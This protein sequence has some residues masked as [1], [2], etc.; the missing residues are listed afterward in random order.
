[1]KLAEMIEYA[2]DQYGLTEETRWTAAEPGVTVLCDSVTDEWVAVLIRKWDR[3][4]DETIEMFDIRCDPSSPLI[5]HAAYIS[6]PF[7]MRR[8]GW[9]GVR[10]DWRA[11][12]EVVFALLDQAVRSQKERGAAIV[13]D[14]PAEIMKSPGSRTFLDT[15]LPHPGNPFVQQ[16]DM[17]PDRIREMLRLYDH[18]DM[19]FAGKC[20]NFYRQAVFMKDYED[21]V[22][23]G[24]G[25]IRRYFPTYHD[26]SIRE[27]RGYFA[28][29][30]SVRQGSCLPA[31]YVYAEIYF[32]ELLNQIGTDS[33]EESLEKMQAFLDMYAEQNRGDFNLGPMKTWMLDFSVI[34]ALPVER[35]QPLL[36]GEEWRKDRM[37]GVLQ[38]PEK[39]DD[40]TVLNA[41]LAFGDAR[42]GR[43]PVLQ[44]HHEIGARLFAWSWRLALRE[45]PDLFDSFFGRLQ[46]MPWHPLDSAVY[47]ER[48]KLEP[49]VCVLTPC[50]TFLYRDGGWMQQVRMPTKTQW[51]KFAGFLREADRQFRLYLKTGNYLKAQT[52]DAWAAPFIQQAIGKVRKE[53]EEAERPKLVL[54]LSRLNGIRRDAEVTRD[55]LLISEEAEEKDQAQNEGKK[56]PAAKDSPEAGSPVSEAAFVPVLSDTGEQ[57]H[58]A[59]SVSLT[60]VQKEILRRLLAGESVRTVLSAQHLM[61]SVTAEAIN[62]AF[63]EEI[64]D[65]VMEEIDGDLGLIPDYLED[66][67]RLL[68]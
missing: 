22:S 42:Q 8:Q 47:W 2:R 44:N 52:E 66:V 54:D 65:S 45:V 3:E 15:P 48:R 51:K 10:L 5:D 35:I 32:Y 58:E 38:A 24:R 26:L 1:M 39:E 12:R 14:S 17:V 37:R 40:E 67:R 33:P 60:S 62:E 30:T 59:C 21:N 34:H 43:S 53:K 56:A 9:V 23:W 28:W 11:E 57:Y 36:E 27:L 18:T 19:S 68:G 46:E 7:R 50:R 13:L 49:S 4:A 64:G 55:S 61:P 41:L 6:S 25:E 31:C 29:R 20:R 16:A 63:Y